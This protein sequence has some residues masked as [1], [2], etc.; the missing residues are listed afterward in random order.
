MCAGPAP[1]RSAV[2]MLDAR[3]SAIARPAEFRYG[4]VFVLTL[5]VVVFLV[6]APAAD[7]SRALAFALESTALVVVVATSRARAD[8]RRA[9]STAG[10]VAAVT[11]VLAIASGVVPTWLE[12]VAG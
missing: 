5:S 6:V 12:F 4:A 8:V 7:W 3:P 9:R 2:R 10:A 1:V 11:C